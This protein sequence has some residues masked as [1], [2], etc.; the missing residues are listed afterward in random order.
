MTTTYNP[1][2][3]TTGLVLYLDAA[4]PKSYPG[5]GTTWTDLTGNGYNGTLVNS[6]TYSN[7]ILT[8]NGSNNYVSITINLQNTSYTT[9]AMARYTGAVNGRIISSNTGNWLMGWW[10]S[11]TD[12]YYAEGFISSSTGGTAET[13]WLCYAATGDY[14]GDSWQ[15]FRN[16]NLIVGP[17][18]NGANGPNGIRLGGSGLGEYS[19]CEVAFVMAYNRVLSAA[20]IQQNFNALRSRYGI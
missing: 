14:A 15:L 11:Q 16:G 4:N 19:T 1:S 5:T 9:M 12:K 3:V 17:N 13:S 2:I 18:A 10:N 6:P 20:E 7:G 8:F